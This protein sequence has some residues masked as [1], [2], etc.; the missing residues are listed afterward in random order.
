MKKYYVAYFPEISE[1]HWVSKFRHQNDEK[2]R[3]VAPHVTLFFPSEMDINE[4]HQEV[5]Q[6]TSNFSKFKV[7]F[8]SVMLM[9]EK[10]ADGITRSSIWSLLSIVFQSLKLAIL[11]KIE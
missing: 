11:L 3:L 2:S 8:R 4:L 9:P 10:G 6:A 1:E 5:Q 7:R